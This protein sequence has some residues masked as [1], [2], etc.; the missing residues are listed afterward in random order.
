MLDKELEKHS[1]GDDD[2][3]TYQELSEE[4]GQVR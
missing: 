3:F 4:L 1:D 2:E